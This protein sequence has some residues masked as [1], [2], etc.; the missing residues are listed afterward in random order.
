MNSPALVADGTVYRFVHKPV[1][2]Q[3]LRLFV[4]TAWRKRAGSSSG[5]Y[6]ILTMSQPPPAAVP[7]RTFPWLA[8][9]IGVVVAGAVGGWFLWRSHSPPVAGPL[10]QATPTRTEPTATL[11]AAA[12]HTTN[13]PTGAVSGPATTK[14]ADLDRLATAAEQALL[15][16]DLDSATRLTEQARA[17]DP[18]H[19]RVKF[20]TTQIAREEARAQ[21]RAAL[22]AAQAAAA[23]GSAATP[24]SAIP[25]PVPQVS[26]NSASVPAFAA[27]ASAP[28]ASLSVSST[29]TVVSA[30]TSTPPA[31][32]ARDHNSVAAIVL[33]RLYSPDPE[34]PELARQT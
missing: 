26:R 19:V 34:F 8:I 12:A 30:P 20:L 23:A 27:A 33:E 29:P 16:G 2:A 31:S 25:T 24:A 3:R 22:L 4:D 13:T 11:A 28:T 5:V 6:P 1:S 14:A 10:P 32:E 15:A 18:D 21:R 17:V 7:T 9:L